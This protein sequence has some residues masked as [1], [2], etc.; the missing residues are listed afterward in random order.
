MAK[1]IASP[2]SE[3]VI[4]IAQLSSSRSV[5]AFY[6]TSALSSIHS[7]IHAAVTATTVPVKG[8]GGRG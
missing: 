1:K 2:L 4:F 6:T 8:G 3:R 5:A 7:H